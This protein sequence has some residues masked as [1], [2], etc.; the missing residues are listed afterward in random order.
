M[1]QTNG[2]TDDKHS[3]DQ[4]KKAQTYTHSQLYV[5]VC[6]F[7]HCYVPLLI[8]REQ[9]FVRRTIHQQFATIDSDEFSLF[10]LLYV[11]THMKLN[12]RGGNETIMGTF[13]PQTML[14]YSLALCKCNRMCVCEL[15][16]FL[17]VLKPSIQR[18]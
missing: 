12:F 13:L 7:V 2:Q 15:N 14:S 11:C 8:S 9:C 6:G 5:C 10:L 17:F 4:E 1:W 3:N 18:Y 16:F